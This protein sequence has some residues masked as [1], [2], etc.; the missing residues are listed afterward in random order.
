MKM[1]CCLYCVVFCLCCLYY[2]HDILF[3]VNECRMLI[4]MAS[5][6]MEASPDT[7]RIMPKIV[8]QHR[9]FLG[10]TLTVF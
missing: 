5:K 3:N 10:R 2:L 6:N 1:L 7:N 9:L 8:R 4:Y